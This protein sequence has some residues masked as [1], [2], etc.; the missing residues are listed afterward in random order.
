M[1]FFFVICMI[2]YVFKIWI[3]NKQTHSGDFYIIHNPDIT[4]E[5]SSIDPHTSS[6]ESSQA[7]TPSGLQDYHIYYNPKL[8]AEPS[9]GIEPSGL[10]LED[11]RY[12]VKMSTRSKPVV[13]MG[14]Y[15]LNF[16]KKNANGTVLFVC[17]HRKAGTNTCCGA[18]VTLKG[19]FS[20][21]TRSVL[22]HNH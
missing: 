17:R 16:K 21:I 19:D 3:K 7:Q 14:N 10:T 22:F 6:T 8:P 4:A 9:T 13:V 12:H 5:P 2:L 11:F 18:T 20:D 1:R 15:Q